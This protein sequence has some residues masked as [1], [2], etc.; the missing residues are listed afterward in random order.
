LIVA[1]HKA[2]HDTFVNVGVIVIGGGDV[3]LK[4]GE[5]VTRQLLLSRIVTVCGPA[6]KPLIPGVLPPGPGVQV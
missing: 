5:G 6:H 4:V 3:I 2:L 1:L